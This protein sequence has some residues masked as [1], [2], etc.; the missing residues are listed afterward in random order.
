MIP[1]GQQAAPCHINAFHP[2]GA[3]RVVTVPPP[4]LVEQK[5][6]TGNKREK[7]RSHTKELCITEPPFEN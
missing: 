5:W 1:L 7:G 6:N 2:Y 3:L 4:F